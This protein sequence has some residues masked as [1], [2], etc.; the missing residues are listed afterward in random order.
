MF[1]DIQHP[2][3]NLTRL[4]IICLMIFNILVLTSSSLSTT[5]L[6]KAS[7]MIVQCVEYDKTH[8]YMFDDIQHPRFN[9]F[10][11]IYHISVHGLSYGLYYVWNITRLTIICLMIFNILVLTSSSLSTTSLCKASAMVCTMCGILQLLAPNI[12]GLLLKIQQEH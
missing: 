10:I 3:F 7:A 11:S 6:C 12:K 5:S 9:L 1:A 4:T 2:R 8:H